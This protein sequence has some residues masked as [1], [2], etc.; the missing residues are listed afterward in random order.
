MKL[1]SCC[2]NVK[3]AII[4]EQSGADRIEFC[5]TL[6]E[7]GLTPKINEIK[8]LLDKVKIPVRVIIRPT[9]SF[10]SNK[11]ILES[12]LKSITS[13]EALGLEGYVFG[14]ATST[15]SIDHEALKKI[16]SITSKP[17]TFHKAID[18]MQD[19]IKAIRE[20]EKYTQV[21]TILS[22]GGKKTAWEGRNVLLQMKLNSSKNILAGGKIT[23]KNLVEHHKFL[24]FDWYHGT[25]IV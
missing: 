5:S 11:N 4:A 23:T 12:C 8:E 2:E 10:Y 13:F 6:K 3:Q 1:E 14:Y 21:D 25:K 19:P 18:A 22:S 20:L 7:Q 15:H 24:Q 17:I 16:L 9:N